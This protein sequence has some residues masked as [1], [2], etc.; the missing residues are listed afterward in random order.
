[1]AA[2]VGR[3]VLEILRHIENLKGSEKKSNLSSINMDSTLFEKYGME[4]G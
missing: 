1:M 2:G 4:L 3:G